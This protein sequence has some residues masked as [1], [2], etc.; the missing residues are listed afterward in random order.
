MS[1]PAPLSAL[2]GDYPVTRALKAGEVRSPRVALEF[3]AVAAPSS[4]FKRVVR[5]AAFDVAELA[6]VTY[7]M[8][9]ERGAPLVLLPA[10]VLA[11]F[12]HPL[13][14]GAAARGP[15]APQELEGRRVGVRSWSVTTGMWMRSILAEDHGVD[16]RRVKWVTFE[17]PHVAGFRD[18]PN[19][20]RAP[21]GKDMVEMLVAGELDA[22]IVT[23]RSL[24][25][26]RLGPLIAD[27]IG[28]A[29]DWQARH[30]GIQVNHM[31][32]VRASLTRSEPDAARE[33]YRLLRESRRAAGDP[34]LN[35]FGVGANR[36]NLEL[37]IERTHAQGLIARRFAVDEL[38]DGVT[39]T[40]D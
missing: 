5:E 1:A 17:E 18:P 10:V 33:V 11:R 14:V 38:F 29:R 32:V 7:L 13:L 2:L 4:A 16:V 30:G 12:Q 31:V 35:P 25:D 34:E 15:L 23:E 9:K 39:G 22:A 20:E 3:A 24:G 19:V 21:Q 8:A 6:L 26:A 36:R 28:A 40:M 37:A 27:P